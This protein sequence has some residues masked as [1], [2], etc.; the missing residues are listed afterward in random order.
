MA[1]VNQERKAQ[2]AAS[3]KKVIPAGWKYSLAVRNHSTIS[4]TISAAPVDLLA[5]YAR[6]ANAKY[7]ARGEGLR[8]E[9]VP[10]HHQVNVYHLDTQFDESLP[11]F[12]AIRTALNAGNHDRSDSQTDYYDVGWYVDIQIGRWDK[13]FVVLPSAAAA[14]A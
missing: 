10:T 3:L 5:E 9:E 13:P 11:A 8:Y 1:Y 4:L 6:I 2:L 7:E 14:A 12:E